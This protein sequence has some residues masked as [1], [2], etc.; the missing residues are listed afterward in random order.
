MNRFRKIAASIVLALLLSVLLIAFVF[1]DIA[2]VSSALRMA[3]ADATVSRIGGV[4]VGPFHF[5]GTQIKGREVR[6]EYSRQYDRFNQQ[7]R[8]QLTNE[9]AMAMG[10][11]FQALRGLEERVL[12]DRAIADAGIVITDAQLRAAVE[13]EPAF[14]A[15]G[16]FS[17]VQFRYILQQN[18]VPEAL[19]LQDKRREMAANQLVGAMM[20][21]ADTPAPL[22][23]ALFRFRK[24]QRIAET[25]TLEAVRMP[26]PPQPTDEQL[27]AFYETVKSRFQVAERRSLSFVM[28]EESDVLELVN[29]TEDMLKQA[30]DERLAR[31]AR[32][33]KREVDQVVVAEEDKAKAIAA[34]VAGGKSLEDASKEILQRD[35]AVIGLGGV[36]QREL[37]P[38]LAKAIFALKEPG[39]VAPV[40]SPL[41]WHVARVTKIEPGENPSFESL[42]PRIEAELRKELASEVLGRLIGE[43]DRE[44]GRADNLDAAA[45]ATKLKLQKVE[46]VDQRG[47][48]TAGRPAVGGEA[49]ADMLGAAWGMTEGKTGSVKELRSGAFYVVR[50][51][52][53]I[54]AR[55]PPLED[56]KAQV[57]VAWIEAE[58]RKAAEAQAKSIVD[59]L[60]AVTDLDTQ[61]QALRLAVKTSK[62]VDRSDRDEA[63][64]LAAAGVTALFKLKPGEAAVVPDTG[65]ATIVRLKEI[66]AADP[67]K[68]AAELQQLDKELDAVTARAMRDAYVQLLERRYGV[69]R[70]PEALATVFRPGEQQQ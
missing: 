38:D 62:P 44:L 8:G 60:G 42:K 10:L 17:P 31:Y 29:I 49:A 14:Q 20:D 36:E 64:G 57:V 3:G 2:G 11:P 69:A 48:D 46:A 18:R 9:A 68:A 35:G 33:E 40:K 22:R 41:G 4:Q 59:K 34:A 7:F 58:R 37:P 1:S 27:K 63:N 21:A 30:F 67:A 12:F 43:F 28:V 52:R 53:V 65:G 45:E 6:D 66:V 56:I 19:Y 39:A 51:D 61:A 70:D 26:D 5:G 24:E 47:F 54:P 55:T 15:D 25:L 13:R 23:D 50:V 16:R 32:P